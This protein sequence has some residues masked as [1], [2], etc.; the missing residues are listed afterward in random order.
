MDH[1]FVLVDVFTEQPFGGNQLAVFPD[2]RGLS[3]VDMQARAR[4]FNFAE[5]TFVLPARGPE[6]AAWVRIFTPRFEIPFA[7]HP[8]V[9]TAAVL[10]ARG[11]IDGSA[12]FELGV[13]PVAVHVE[14]RGDL[15][16]SRLT[17]R[18]GAESPAVTPDPAAL[19][20]TLSLSTVDVIDGFYATAGLPFCFA[21]LRDADAVD[22]AVFN[23]PAWGEHLAAGWSPDI[24]LFAGDPEPGAKVYARMFAP[25]SGVS[26]DAATGSASAALVGTLAHRWD[27]PDGSYPLTITQGVHMGR[28]SRIE[29]EATK[30][31]GTV[32]TITVGGTSVIVGGGHI[33]G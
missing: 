12:V 30:S 32:H 23:Q 15:P 31:A 18:R 27:G 2:A 14:Q 13:G 24:Y 28:P 16:Y 7:G 1:E 29:A 9:G 5:S 10:A 11:A 22:R 20:A 26:E 8:T 33:R 21:H 4:E 3:D 25:S 6:N 17:L 19:A